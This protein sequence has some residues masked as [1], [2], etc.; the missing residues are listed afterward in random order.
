MRLFLILCVITLP[1]IADAQTRHY[2]VKQQ[3]K[4]LDVLREALFDVTGKPFLYTS[5]SKLR[6]AFDSVA[7]DLQTPQTARELF[8][9]FAFL[10]AQ[11]KCGHTQ[12]FMNG[13]LIRDYL[14]FSRTLPLQVKI[15]GERMYAI[16][17]VGKD[18]RIIKGN[19]IVS[20]NSK[21][22]K[23]IL[24]KMYELTS[25]DGDNITLKQHYLSESF[26]FFYFVAFGEQD[27]FLIK[28]LDD[29]NEEIE[30]NVASVE[31]DIKAFNRSYKKSPFITYGGS[32]KSFGKLVTDRSSPVQTWFLPSFKYAK[33]AKYHGYIDANMRRIN[34]DESEF[35]ILDL[36]GN[37]GGVIQ[38]YL[39]GYFIA[40][41]DHIAYM[42]IGNTE[43]PAYRQH[44]KRWS[45]SYLKVRLSSMLQDA[46]Q[47]SADSVGHFYQILNRPQVEQCQ[48]RLVVLV[49]GMTFSSGSNVAAN[50]KDKAGAIIIGEETCGSYKH[51]NTGQLALKLPKSKF[52]MVINPVYYSNNVDLEMGSSGLIPDILVDP[53]FEYSK[54]ND[55]FINA[56]LDFI[57]REKSKV[58]E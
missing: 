49:D 4:D 8:T 41:Q 52:Q 50:L 6:A 13:R 28:A 56:A 51:G 3:L 21:S 32:S 9:A 23:D 12:I 11:V 42:E 26:N 22:A 33:G 31:T 39:M 24:T 45:K 43:K 5:R 16:T 47:L 27:S 53:R 58:G 14:I 54:N 10:T 15:V 38:T 57:E 29:Q 55:P 30:V 18:P 37:L 19:E 25:S 1:L 7:T 17:E 35:L 46:S 20:I 34:K 44:Y 2:R 36:R 40:E 48:K